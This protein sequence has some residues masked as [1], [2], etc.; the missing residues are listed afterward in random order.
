M[1]YLLLCR[2]LTY[3]QRAEKLLGRKG[4][5]AAIIKAPKEAAVNGCSYCVRIPERHKAR[6]LAILE[7]GDLMPQRVYEQSDGIITEVS[8]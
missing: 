3:A 1:Y 5:S 7:G 6:A 2:S 4:L 8:V